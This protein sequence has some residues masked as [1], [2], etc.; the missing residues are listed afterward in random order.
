[1]TVTT[2]PVAFPFLLAAFPIVRLAAQNARE[3]PPGELAAPLAIALGASLAIW[4]LARWVYG[5]GHRA[6]LVVAATALLFLTFDG[7]CSASDS[8]ATYLSS[9]W[10]GTR[11]RTPAWAVL[12]AEAVALAGVAWLVA[13]RPKEPARWTPA[14]NVFAG[15]LLALPLVQA[16]NT[17][18]RMPPAPPSSPPAPLAD[19]PAA[20]KRPDIYY[21]I[22]DGFARGDILKEQFGYDIEP[23]FERL[24]AKGFVVARRATANYCQTPLSLSSSLNADYL[25]KAKDDAEAARPP[26]K[27]LFRENAV[28]RALRPLGYR[29]VTFGSG[30]DFTEFPGNDVYLSPHRHLSDFHRMIVDTTP[31]RFLWPD[32]STRD[33]FALARERTLHTFDRLPAVARMRGP[34]FTVAHVVS[35]HPPFVFGAEGEDVS[36]RPKRCVLSDG[37][38]YRY[39][40]GGEETYVPGYRAQVEFLVKQ[41]E[42]AIDQIL[43]NSAEPPIIVLQ[44]DHGSGMHLDMKSAAKTDHRER[45]GILAAVYLPGG[46]RE[47]LTDVISP[48]N[49]FRAVFNNEFGTSLPLLPSESYY[50][51]WPRPFDFVRVTD[52]VREA[53]PVAREAAAGGAPKGGGF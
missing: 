52:R 35:P 37:D 53:S 24:E 49:I 11:A 48:V 8:A 30:F 26:D 46:G 28:I 23:F 25:P 40:Y 15:I 43:A 17:W 10:V 19:L 34:K 39:F 20:S 22:L 12:L 9:L 21:I 31:A 18:V 29:F 44:S 3:V 7:V 47:G 16:A 45:M 50:S 32:P 33:P 2:R 38:V 5:D 51:T 13:R 42:R 14:L 6:G 27:T 4:L 36:P 1:M 41:T